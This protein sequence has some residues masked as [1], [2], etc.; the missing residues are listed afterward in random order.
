MLASGPTCPGPSRSK[1]KRVHL[2]SWPPRAGSP[3]LHLPNPKVGHPLPPTS[4]R[5]CPPPLPPA[6]LPPFA[7]PGC[8]RPRAVAASRTMSPSRASTGERLHNTWKRRKRRGGGEHLRRP[9]ARSLDHPAASPPTTEQFTFRPPPSRNGVALPYLRALTPEGKWTC[10]SAVCQLTGLCRKMDPPAGCRVGFWRLTR[11][12]LR[13]SLIPGRQENQHTERPV[14]SP[15]TRIS[16]R[17]N[18]WR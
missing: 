3:A 12:L 17:R 4:F 16:A 8:G 18:D 5:P 9:R 1:A 2:P 15:P 7:V 14:S 13:V 10:P 6:Y 11:L